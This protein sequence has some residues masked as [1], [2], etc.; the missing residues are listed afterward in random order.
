MKNTAP[1]E[2]FP[3]KA[4]R[5]FVEGSAVWIIVA[6]VVFFFL[7]RKHILPNYIG[8]ISLV[9]LIAASVTLLAMWI[10]REVVRFLNHYD[11]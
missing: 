7:S 5:S 11:D 2:N 1:E 3:P 4:V 6:S 8:V 10:K 9:T